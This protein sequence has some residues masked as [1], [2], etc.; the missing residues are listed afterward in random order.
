MQTRIELTS[1]AR[2]H[3]AHMG[4]AGALAA[5]ELGVWVQVGDLIELASTEGQ[6]AFIVRL[7]RL[8]VGAEGSQTLVVQLD[9]PARL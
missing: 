1:T 4:V 2:L 9:H 3:A 5:L 8:V 6:H 7:R